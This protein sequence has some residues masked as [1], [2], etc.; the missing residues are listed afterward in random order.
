M[1]KEPHEFTQD[2]MLAKFLNHL[3]SIKNYWANVKLEPER[4]NVQERLDGLCFSFL[5]MLDGSSMDIP[6]C[7]IVPTPHP[8]D[9]EYLKDEGSNWWPNQVEK[10]EKSGLKTISGG[11]AMHEFWHA[12]KRGEF[13][14]VD[15]KLVKK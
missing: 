10:L 8:S 5:T 1:G 7:E 11:H 14:I 3:K 2:E 4:D 12:F 6:S 13:T 15:G 9:E